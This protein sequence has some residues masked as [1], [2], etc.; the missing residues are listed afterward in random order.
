MLRCLLTAKLY[1]TI[2]LLVGACSTVPGH[3]PQAGE[4]DRGVRTAS[5]A[6]LPYLVVPL[7]PLTVSKSNHHQPPAFQTEFR[8]AF[9]GSRAMTVGVGDRLTIH[10][11][12]PTA[13][14]VFATAEKKQTSLTATV[15]EEG[16][17]YIPYAGRVRASG[18]PV[19]GLRRA[20][21][22][23]L[24]GKAVEP[25][26]Q[27][28][29]EENA[30]NKVVLLGDLAQP[31]QFSVPLQ[32]LRLM[33]AIAQAGGTKTPVFETVATITRGQ[34]RGT[35]RLD[36][37]ANVP[38]NNIWL[39]PS[40]SVVVQHRPRTYSAFGS[41]QQV[42]LMAFQSETMTMAEALAEVKGLRNDSADAG[43]IFLFRFEESALAH[44]FEKHPA[45]SGTGREAMAGAVPV[46][47]R[48]DFNRPDSF[49]L[50]QKFMM[51]DKDVLYVA[52][53]PTAE[54]GKFLSTIVSPLLGSARVAASFG[55]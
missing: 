1:L 32:G 15:D 51:K 8:D 34:H 24:R 52:N 28:L 23:A 45:A 43:G 40:D 22:E 46:V 36:H 41:V 16:L 13:D 6:P 50:A 2:L 25:Q 37:V 39:A 35:M 10:I 30:S 21:E 17:I 7:D 38:E 9:G 20:I 26:V 49:F 19:E 55:D 29:L 31:G 53:H 27:V 3:G 33:E 11:W 4:I 48:L 42:G 47:Y 5:I 12:E 44:A 14:G 18:R 54:L